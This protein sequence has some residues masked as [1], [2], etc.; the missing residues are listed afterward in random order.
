PED[1]MTASRRDSRP[2]VEALLAVQ[3]LL[4]RRLLGQYHDDQL[5]EEVSWD[6]VT[7]AFERWAAEPGFFDNMNLAAWAQRLATWR[8]LHILRARGRHR[9]LPGEHA[10]EE[11]V[12]AIRP[13][14]GGEGLSAEDRELIWQALEQLPAPDRDILTAHYFDGQTDQEVGT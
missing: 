8:A 5:A 4:Y 12:R 10:G 14:R 7:N 6:C 11:S 1:H 2:F 13:R 3:P 9:P